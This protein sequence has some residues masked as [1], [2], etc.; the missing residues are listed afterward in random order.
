MLNLLL[1]YHILCWRDLKAKVFHRFLLNFGCKQIMHYKVFNHNA[2]DSAYWLS[3]PCYKVHMNG[4]KGWLSVYAIP[5][6][7]FNIALNIKYIPN[8]SVKWN[9]IF[10]IKLFHFTSVSYI[11]WNFRYFGLYGSKDTID[12]I[13]LHSSQLQNWMWTASSVAYS[14][15]CTFFV[16]V[17][18]TPRQT[19]IPLR[20]Q[21]WVN[22][23][24]IA[25]P[26]QNTKVKLVLWFST[27]SGPTSVEP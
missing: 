10:L 1:S 2:Y 19:F 23:F 22:C 24:S 3:I 6:K 26:S 20:F 21:S 8:K 9:N 4:L 14:Q 15:Y 11:T 13:L 17:K 25:I 7:D 12:E 18:L 27:V 16:S 5:C